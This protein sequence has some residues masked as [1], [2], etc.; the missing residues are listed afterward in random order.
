MKNKKILELPNDLS[1]NQPI[2]LFDGGCT[3]CSNSVRFLLRHNSSG[4]LQFASLESATGSKIVLL[5]GE[6]TVPADTLFL[7]QDSKLFC[8][9]TAALKITA[10]LDFP[11]NALSI[12]VFIPASV[13]DT[14]YRFVAK[15][16]YS[17][18]GRESFCIS[19]GMEYQ[20]RFLY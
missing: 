13:R 17:W 19:E 12:L 14:I 10:H 18:F 4:N 7:L 11:L 9:S 5:A 2:V 3:L 20:E 15:K 1:N 8:Y 6:A 16:R